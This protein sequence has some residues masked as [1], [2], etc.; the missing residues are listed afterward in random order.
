MGSFELYKLGINCHKKEVD[1]IQRTIKHTSNKVKSFIWL[2]TW[3]L[4]VELVV[5]EYPSIWHAA[6]TPPKYTDVQ[7]INNCS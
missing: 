4:P 2:C 7:I 5:F 1:F 6:R 3:C